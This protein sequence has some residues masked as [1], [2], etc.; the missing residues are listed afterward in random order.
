MEAVLAGDSTAKRL[1]EELNIGRMPT[2][3]ST[4]SN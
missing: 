4:D 2:S 1:V 3:D